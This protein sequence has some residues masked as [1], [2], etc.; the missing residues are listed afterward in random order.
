[1]FLNRRGAEFSSSTPRARSSTY[2]FKC[3]RLDPKEYGGRIVFYYR[4]AVLTGDSN[5]GLLVGGTCILVSLLP[6]RLITV[7]SAIFQKNPKVTWTA[8]FVLGSMTILFGLTY[9]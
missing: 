6:S 1:V 3:I 9:R 8:L 4:R 7:R 2:T 5:I